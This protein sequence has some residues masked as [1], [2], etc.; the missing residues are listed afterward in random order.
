MMEQ[1]EVDFREETTFFLRKEKAELDA[2]SL[3]IRLERENLEKDKR[4]DGEKKEN[5]KSA[6]VDGGMCD[7]G[8][9]E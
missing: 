2:E 5:T 1:K 7:D 4:R 3:R 9:K 6:P 8:T